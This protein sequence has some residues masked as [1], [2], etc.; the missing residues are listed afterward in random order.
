[1]AHRAFSGLVVAVHR[2]REWSAFSR[3]MAARGRFVS[4]EDLVRLACDDAVARGRDFGTVE[5]AVRYLSAVVLAC[6]AE[7]RLPGARP[8]RRRRPA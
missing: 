7:R 6:V 2:C 4:A 1:M 5:T 3:A 8:G